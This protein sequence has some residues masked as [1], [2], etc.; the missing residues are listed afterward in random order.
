LFVSPFRNV[1][2]WTR[3]ESSSIEDYEIVP[4]AAAEES[5]ESEDAESE[6]AESA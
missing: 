3:A 6:V 5:E 1:E 4:A 2:Y